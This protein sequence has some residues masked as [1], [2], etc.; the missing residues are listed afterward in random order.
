MVPNRAKEKPPP[1]G[2]LASHHLL[3]AL[4]DCPSPKTM[5]YASV[6]VCQCCAAS[7]QTLISLSKWHWHKGEAQL[8]WVNSWIWSAVR[9]CQASH[10]GVA[11]GNHYFNPSLFDINRMNKCFCS[12]LNL[13]EFIQMPM[14]TSKSFAFVS[15]MDV[16]GRQAG[17]RN[18]A[19]LFAFHTIFCECV[20]VSSGS[21]AACFS[22]A[23]HRVTL[24]V[25]VSFSS[26]RSQT[27][28]DQQSE[29]LESPTML[30]RRE[31]TAT[32]QE[33]IKSTRQELASGWQV[34]HKGDCIL[35]SREM[36]CY[37]LCI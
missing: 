11:H 32:R 15:H 9:L 12:R 25:R 36:P 31:C 26:L 19:H 3:K 28:P 37:S 17:R 29:G 22:P 8:E 21:T 1:S 10:R 2:L 18:T 24:L 14:K 6:P 30:W 4:A 13:K 7:T 23:P 34:K 27:R 16:A 35:L 33:P 20:C 5:F